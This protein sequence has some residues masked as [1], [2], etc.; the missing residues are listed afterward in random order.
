MINS[1]NNDWLNPEDG[2]ESNL[3]TITIYKEMSPS[4]ISKF[5]KEKKEVR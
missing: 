4:E 5:K 2:W 1:N 3:K